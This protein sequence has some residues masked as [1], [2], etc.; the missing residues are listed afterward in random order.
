[1]LNNEL[2]AAIELFKMIVG[3]I[4]ILTQGCIVKQIRLTSEV[5]FTWNMRM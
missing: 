4:V 2:C 3:D 5:S 1:M